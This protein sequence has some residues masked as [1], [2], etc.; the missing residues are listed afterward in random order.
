MKNISILQKKELKKK[1]QLLYL[2]NYGRTDCDGVNCK[3]CPFS[4][5][6]SKKKL[7]ICYEDLELY[8]PEIAIEVVENWAKNNS[9]K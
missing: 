5:A 9:V 1:C 4:K 2:I 7:E 8:Y 6:M 3:L